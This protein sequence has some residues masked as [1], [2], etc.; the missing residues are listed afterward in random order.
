RSENKIKD[1]KR[2]VGQGE[3]VGGV[4]APAS[5]EGTIAER[6]QRQYHHHFLTRHQNPDGGRRKP[7]LLIRQR[8]QKVLQRKPGEIDVKEG[9]VHQALAS[10]TPMRQESSSSMAPQTALPA[11]GKLL[12][13]SGSSPFCFSVKSCRRPEVSIASRRCTN[14]SPL[15][16]MVQ[17]STM[18]SRSF[19]CSGAICTTGTSIAIASSM[20]VELH[21]IATSAA[22]SVSCKETSGGAM[23]IRSRPLNR[24][25]RFS[26]SCGCK[27]T[28]TLKRWSSS[29]GF[30]AASTRRCSASVNSGECDCERK[31]T[32]Q[33][34]T[35]FIPFAS[36]LSRSAARDFLA[37]AS[38]S[39]RG[40]PATIRFDRA[41]GRD[42]M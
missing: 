35:W 39:K 3:L 18:P 20:A 1:K 32:S 16:A 33:R 23:V 11:T 7:S 41:P 19:T 17:V 8:Q 42:S 12:R 5:L 29:S 13:Y 15:P 40:A 6:Q 10:I 14:S 2:S 27:R 38:A 22:D 21:E 25:K 30:K 26:V 36:L 9:Q 24:Q 37:F 31:T 34:P 4:K 28:T